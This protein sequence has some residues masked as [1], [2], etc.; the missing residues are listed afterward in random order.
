MFNVLSTKT[1]NHYINQYPEAANALKKLYQELSKSSFDSFND[2]KV[3][4][5]SASIVGDNRVVFNVVGNKY[6]LIVRVNFEYKRIMIKWFGTHKEYDQINAA[7]VE[8]LI[9]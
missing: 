9:D 7:K 6:R 5:G 3:V 1:L 4:Y 2:L 8:F